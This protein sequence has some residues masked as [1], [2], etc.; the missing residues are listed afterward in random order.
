MICTNCNKE[1]TSQRSIVRD[2]NIV[3]GCDL[4]LEST[5]Q[6]ANDLNANHNRSAQR[7]EHRKDIV[8]PWE[9][10]EYAKAYPED[11][12]KRFGDEVFRRLS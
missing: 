8:Q 12:R 10:K 3:D 1:T 9:S 2:N 6:Q 11:A 5:F 4:C 7:A